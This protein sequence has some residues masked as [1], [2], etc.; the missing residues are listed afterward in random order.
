M[1]SSF[2]EV[3]FMDAD[4]TALVDPTPFFDMNEY[5][6]TGAV[7]WPDF[8]AVN[9]NAAL[10][11]I[12]EKRPLPMMS[13]ESGQMLLNRQRH[14]KSLALADYFNSR[15]PEFFYELAPG[16]ADLFLFA[17]LALEAPFHMTPTLLATAGYMADAHVFC[18]HTM[19]Q[20]H[21]NGSGQ[22]VFAHRNLL[23][24]SVSPDDT[25][26][27]WRDIKQPRG[28]PEEQ[29]RYS[30]KH[31]T[32]KGYSITRWI[33]TEACVCNDGRMKGCVD[34]DYEV[35]QTATAKLTL[36]KMATLEKELLTL[37]G[38]LVDSTGKMRASWLSTWIR[39]VSGYDVDD[40]APLGD[41][42][43]EL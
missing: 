35:S 33:E 12:I 19:L 31:G 40:I 34:M 16:D 30:A 20:F 5:V 2:Q 13:H 42:A 15:G 43:S 9:F 6:S 11:D 32:S 41:V 14:A 3:L 23:K 18:G 28:L 22:A 8:T 4:N 26:V 39:S 10:W 7:L 27:R 38:S 29:L 25:E 36:Q 17:W 37:R 24:W 1:K 21:P